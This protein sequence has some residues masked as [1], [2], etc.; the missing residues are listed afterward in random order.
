[1][2]ENK[3]QIAKML[4]LKGIPNLNYITNY[5]YPLTIY[6]IELWL[7]DNFIKFRHQYP[8]Q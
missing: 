7:Y 2:E 1:M 5:E 3:L 8:K 6:G 4:S